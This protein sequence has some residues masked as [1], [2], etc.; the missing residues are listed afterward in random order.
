MTTETPLVDELIKEAQQKNQK[1]QNQPNVNT[2]GFYHDKD[3]GKIGYDASEYIDYFGDKY[4]IPVKMELDYSKERAINDIRA[5]AQGMSLGTSDEIE[6]FLTSLGSDKKY[7]EILP[8][9]RQKINDYRIS[10]PGAAITSEILGG[11]LTGKAFVG[12]TAAGTFKRVLGGGTVYGGGA[13]DPQTDPRLEEGKDLTLGESARIRTEEAG[14]S[15]LWT[16]PFAWLSKIMQPTKESLSFTKKG[17]EVTPGQV[18]GGEFKAIEDVAEKLPFIGTGIKSAKKNVL[19]KFNELTFNEFISDL[20]NALK[21]QTLVFPKNA[22]GK[23]TGIKFPKIPETKNKLGNEMF[24]ETNR[25]VNKAYDKILEKLVIKDKK[26]LQNQV[27]SILNNYEG[28]LPTGIKKQLNRLIF[29]RFNNKD[30]LVGEA[31]KRAHSKIRLRHRQSGKSTSADAADLHDMYGDILDLFGDNIVKYNPTTYFQY[32]ALDKIY[33]KFLSLEKAVVS[34]KS[35]TNYYF[36]PQ[37]LINAGISS[38]KAKSAREIAKGNAPFSA[39]GREAEEVIGSDASKDVIPYYAISAL[40][41]TGVY[42]GSGEDWEE[43]AKRGGGLIAPLML[44][45]ASYKSPTARKILSE[46][47][48]KSFTTRVGPYLGQQNYFGLRDKK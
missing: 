40:T 20:N 41:G 42:A 7:S 37:Q 9:V 2:F 48:K 44:T 4:D 39:L 13:A 46:M 31:L 34:A 36:S 21:R 5:S 29:N 38:A 32:S 33:P 3:K 47:L 19:K 17:A 45:G 6:A 10:N 1:I 24:S 8:E 25:Y 26:T 35:G 15:A 23:K 14:K 18:V 16:L 11:I 28:Q 30:E 22:E 12:K 27:D 43:R